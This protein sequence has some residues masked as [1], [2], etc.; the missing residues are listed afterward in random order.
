MWS[1]IARH[2][3]YHTGNEDVLHQEMTNIMYA[4]IQSIRDRTWIESIHDGTLEP[5]HKNIQLLDRL[6]KGLGDVLAKKRAKR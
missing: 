6:I 3:L 4:Q 5:H 2:M 1:R